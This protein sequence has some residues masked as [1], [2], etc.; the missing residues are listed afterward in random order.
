MRSTEKGPICKCRRSSFNFKQ[1]SR[2]W[3]DRGLKTIEKIRAKLPITI[4]MWSSCRNPSRGMKDCCSM[5]T[6]RNCN[7]STRFQHW[8]RRTTRWGYS[9]PTVSST[10]RL[11]T[12]SSNWPCSW[13][14]KNA[15][16]GFWKRRMSSLGKR[17]WR[18]SENCT[19]KTNAS[20]C[21]CWTSINGK[22]NKGCESL[23]F[24]IYI[25]SNHHFETGISQGSADYGTKR[26]VLMLTIYSRR[27]SHS[28][29]PFSVYQL[30]KLG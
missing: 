12:W 3:K 24:V 27:L 16:A 18:F 29:F 26:S 22:N 19:K 23:F 14:R 28:L 17:L 6:V 7:W 30:N 21:L 5:Q 10:A 11:K 4:S 8:R 25:S 2:K 15:T 1:K 13:S 9:W 20:N